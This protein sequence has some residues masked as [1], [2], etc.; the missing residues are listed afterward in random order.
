MSEKFDQYIT[1]TLLLFSLHM[2]ENM[3]SVHY[4]VKTALLAQCFEQFVFTS[5]D[6]GDS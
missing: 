2:N 4:L 3:F 6:R 1:T 5:Q